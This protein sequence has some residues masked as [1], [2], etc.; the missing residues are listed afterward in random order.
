M[1]DTRGQLGE[2]HPN[3]DVQRD[4]E[5]HEEGPEP[6]ELVRLKQ[7][8]LPRRTHVA[9]KGRA[10]PGLRATKDAGYAK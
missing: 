1:T 7:R 2:G 9:F 4:P 8:G 6:L 3:C 5:E 10:G